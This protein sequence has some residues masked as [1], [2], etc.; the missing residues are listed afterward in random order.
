[1]YLARLPLLLAA[2]AAT[3]AS[4]A[5]VLRLEAGFTGLD[6]VTGIH[7][8]PGAPAGLLILEQG[9]ALR[10]ARDGLLQPAPV[11]DLRDRVLSTAFEQGLTGFALAPDYPQDARVYVHYIRADGASVI[12]RFSWP[13]PAIPIDTGGEE[14]LLVVPQP[15]PTHNCNQLAFGPDGYLYIGCGDGGKGNG[16][17]LDPRLLSHA[18]GKLLRIDVSPAVG[19]AIP[20]DN[21]YRGRH[22]AL[23]EIWATGLRNPYRFSF[24]PD[25]GEL[26][27]GDV[28]Q[29]SREELNRLPAG[30]GGLDLGWPILEG[31]ACWPAGSPCD[32]EGLW[33]PEHVYLHEE[34]RCAVIAGPRVRDA[35]LPV[36]DGAVLF[37]DFCSGELFALRETEDQHFV[38]ERLLREPGLAPTSFGHDASGGLWLGTY[39]FGSARVLRIVMAEALFTDGFEPED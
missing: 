20:P 36:L 24:D 32:D 18:L 34:G 13:D 35:G 11:L 4:A 39:G 1:M 7:A 12:A 10:R 21:P 5:G 8:D 26:W 37:A 3:T 38:A 30:L 9:G 29:A 25:S 31:D 17:I 14:V 27:L 15:H 23:P 16:P 2:L 19:Y 6:R 22:G 28:G 33:P